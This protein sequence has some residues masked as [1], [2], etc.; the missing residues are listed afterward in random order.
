MA[1]SISQQ[2]SLEA[3]AEAE[4]AAVRAAVAA[5]T[6]SS[7]E[8]MSMAAAAKLF[9]GFLPAAAAAQAS[10]GFSAPP[11]EM[12]SEAQQRKEAIQILRMSKH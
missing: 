11:G 9:H 2:R 7:G 6:S 12:S 4:A 10:A 1:G 8:P 3:E 5:V